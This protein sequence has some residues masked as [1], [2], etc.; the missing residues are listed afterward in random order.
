MTYG[1]A[2]TVLFNGNE[3]QLSSPFPL[4]A[5][6]H[7]VKTVAA[8]VSAQA[9]LVLPFIQIIWMQIVFLLQA[10]NMI[11]VSNMHYYFTCLEM[12]IVSTLINDLKDCLISVTT[13]VS[14]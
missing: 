2:R 9:V 6:R 5:A 1:F 11:Q 3:H 14:C 13:S 4:A 12:G 10:S 7:H 8:A